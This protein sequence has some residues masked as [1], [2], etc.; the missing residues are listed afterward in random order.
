MDKLPEIITYS[1][2]DSE[3]TLRLFNEKAVASDWFA[4]M[5]DEQLKTA[6][7]ERMLRTVGDRA[8]VIARLDRHMKRGGGVEVGRQPWK[9]ML[10]TSQSPRTTT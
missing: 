10:S 2:H 4:L 9:S 8:T 6:C 7:V 1:A 3:E 5:T